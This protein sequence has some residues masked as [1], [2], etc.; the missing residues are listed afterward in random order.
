[1]K[2]AKTLTHILFPLLVG[3]IIGGAI[4]G[5]ISMLIWGIV[6][7]VLDI[8]I[9]IVL[10]RFIDKASYREDWENL[11]FEEKMETAHA[12]LEQTKQDMKKK[13]IDTDAE[14]EAFCDEFNCKHGLGKYSTNKSDDEDRSEEHALC[15]RLDDIYARLTEKGGARFIQGIRN[16]EAGVLL[17][18]VCNQIPHA[19]PTYTLAGLFLV[20]VENLDGRP[21]IVFS[22]QYALNSICQNVFIF[23]VHDGNEKIR[24]F[25][26]ETDF[27]AYVLCEYSG[28]SHLNYG[29]LELESVPARIK[30]ILKDNS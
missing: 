20:S 13:G 22:F 7:L 18:D 12:L 27:S 17:L 9:G 3:L 16:D 21:S 15:D 23:L 5:N 25:A 1:M 10:Q 29:K 8:A 2:G 11:T 24:L 28:N 14:L 26:V 4:A 30:E 6:L 19:P